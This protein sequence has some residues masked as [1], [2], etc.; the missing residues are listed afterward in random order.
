LTVGDLSVAMNNPSIHSYT[1]LANPYPSQ[2]SFTAFQASN[3]NINNKMWTYS[4]F[5][6][7]NYTTLL[8]G[9]VVNAAAGYDN[10]SGAIIANGQAFFVEANTNGNVTFHESHKSTS[11]IP[12]TKYFDSTSD[13]LIRIGLKTPNHILLDETV[14]RFNK[15]GKKQYTPTIDAE[16]F[17]SAAQTLAILKGNNR[18]AIAT[19]PN[20]GAADTIHLSVSSSV[21]GSFQLSFS[22]FQ[23]LLANNT[24]V[25]I[26]LS[27]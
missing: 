17:N 8:Q 22:D 14:I 6:N 2:I 4:P 12:N 9:I 27:K 16:S 24:I 23:P 11:L 20:N 7:G 21:N 10:T 15:N 26:H 19:Y 1:L 25:L 3:S 13:S 18:M 5:G